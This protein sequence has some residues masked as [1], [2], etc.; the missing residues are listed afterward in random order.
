MGELKDFF[1]IG[2]KILSDYNYRVYC[3]SVLSQAENYNLKI[4]RKTFI[5][6]FVFDS[7]PVMLSNINKLEGIAYQLGRYFW[8]LEKSLSDHKRDLTV[9]AND[10]IIKYTQEEKKIKILIAL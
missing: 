5:R 9:M 3:Q 6:A 1:E 2:M 4:S 10:E 8:F 7:N